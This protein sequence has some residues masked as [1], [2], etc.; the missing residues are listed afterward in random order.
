V[1]G[2]DVLPFD[3]VEQASMAVSVLDGKA[4]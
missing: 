3:D 1:V 4:I 2:S